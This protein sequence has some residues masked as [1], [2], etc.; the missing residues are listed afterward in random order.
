VIALVLKIRRNPSN[1]TIPIIQ[2]SIP[3]A[4]P[5]P[6]KTKKGKVVGFTV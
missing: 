3:Y 5:Q 2:T 4:V 6:V 1:A